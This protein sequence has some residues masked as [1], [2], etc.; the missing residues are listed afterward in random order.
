MG[1]CGNS[2]TESAIAATSGAMVW[3]QGG[4]FHMGSNRFYPEER[5]V[6]PVRVDGFWMDAYPV[7]NAAFARFVEATGYRTVAEQTPEPRDYPQ[8]DPACLVPGSLCFRPLRN[9]AALIRQPLSW[10]RYQPG[11]CW[12]HP[13]GPGSSIA[14][15]DAHPVVH[16]CY[17]D[18]LAFAE[19]AGKSLPTEAEW[20]FAARGGLEQAEYAWGHEFTPGGRRLAN[21]WLGEFPWHNLANGGHGGTSAVGSFPPN[22]YGLLDMIGNVW[23]WTSDHFLPHHSPPARQT[24]CMPSNPHVATPAAATTRVLKGGSFLCAPNYCR[25][26]RPAARQGQSADSAAVH[27]GF[28]CIVRRWS[29]AAHLLRKER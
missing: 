1:S 9:R 3:I 2:G 27:I 21:T 5:P 7:T 22:S 10:W 28:R 16:V 17:S 24:C 18:A 23:E 12:R 11:A 6:H 4:A 29:G 20:E 25:R 26:Y 8:I 13:Q 19:W 15:K 14:G